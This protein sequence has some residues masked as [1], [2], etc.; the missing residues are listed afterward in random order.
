[1]KIQRKAWWLLLGVVGLQAQPSTQKW[2]LHDC[3]QYAFQ[4]NITIKNTE[5]DQAA[6][7]ADVLAAWGNLLPNIA[8]SGS[9][10]WNIGLNQN[11]TTGLLENQTT[12]FT[13]VG[14]SANVPIYR[15]MQLINRLNRA[16]LNQE[17]AALQVQKIKDDVGLNVANAYL[18]IL[19]NKERL[20]AQQEQLKNSQKQLERVKA[21]VEIGTLPKGDMLDSEATVAAEVQKTIEAENALFLSKLSLAQLLQLKDYASFDI[22]ENEVEVPLSLVL[23]ESPQRILEQA[24]A[25]RVEL[26]IAQAQVQLARKDLHIAKANFQPNLSGFYSFSTRASSQGRIV[27]YT[28]NPSRPT[29]QV[30]VVEGTNQAVVAPNFTPVL[31]NPLSVMD[32]FSQYKGHN[33]GLQL[34]I[35]I[36]NG[37]SARAGWQRA[38]INFEKNQNALATAENDLERN[39]YTA[40]TNAQGAQKA[41][42]S[43]Q[44]S[45]KARQQ[46]Y[47]FAQEKYQI[48]ALNSFEFNQAQLLLT[49]ATADYLRAK[50]DY[51][52]K[53]KI[54]EFYFGIPLT[55]K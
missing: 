51:L 4:H 52:F 37:W 50:Y 7:G 26:K 2:S 35:P 6:T 27:D 16:R 41:F 34:N 17:A 38:K 11:I 20:K 43:A 10:S 24:K 36:L 40:I 19:F 21:S 22:A 46:A 32:Q 44:L 25:N 53:V 8:A 28:L 45:L 23:Q 29:Y 42:E 54:V 55:Q 14:L 9:H 1:M 31:G 49:S 48:G 30:G 3:V 39:V 47:A 5:L 33:F 15:G 18:Q 13:S 12:Q